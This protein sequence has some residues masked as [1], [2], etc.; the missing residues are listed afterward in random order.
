[1]ALLG[2]YNK[3]NAVVLL[4]LAVSVF[5]SVRLR[6][7]MNVDVFAYGLLMY[8]DVLF[9]LTG[10]KFLLAPATLEHHQRFNFVKDGW[11]KLA[12]VLPQVGASVRGVI[13]RHVD[14]ETMRILDL[15]ED[16][17]DGVYSRSRINAVLDTGATV[18]ADVY[19]GTKVA[20]EAAS[21]VWNENEFFMRN[22]RYY[23]DSVIPN[24]LDAIKE[25]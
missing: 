19:M 1:M 24:F 25:K 4:R 18:S 17:D 16:V 6:F 22:H 5:L 7:F 8:D 3:V 11:P 10:K 23:L 20:T 13:I 12:V 2:G 14:P 9:S 15:F 21:G